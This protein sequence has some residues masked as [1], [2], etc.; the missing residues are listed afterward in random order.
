MSES[1][2]HWKEEEESMER[3]G[4]DGASEQSGSSVMTVHPKILLP[5]STNKTLE[6]Y[7]TDETR[8]LIT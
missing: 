3:K 5:K 6:K 2:T 1:G 4:S 8:G 7:K